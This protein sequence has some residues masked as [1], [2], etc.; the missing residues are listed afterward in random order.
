MRHAVANGDAGRVVAFYRGFQQASGG[1]HGQARSHR[2]PPAIGGHPIYSRAQIAD[3]YERRRKG[4]FNDAR[5]RPIENDIVAAAREG[6]V[7]SSFDKYGN[8]MRLR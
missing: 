4:E 1:Q 8:E 7:T 3:L 2:R 5:W 6:R